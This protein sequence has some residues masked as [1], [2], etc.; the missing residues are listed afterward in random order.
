MESLTETDTPDSEP[1]E[2]CHDN[3]QH[4]PHTAVSQ[5]QHPCGRS[6][7]AIWDLPRQNLPQAINSTSVWT[8]SYVGEDDAFYVYVFLYEALQ[9][10][11]I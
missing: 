10:R 9:E 7:K 1:I 3:P 6:L 4:K 11:D 5:S 8:V 2:P